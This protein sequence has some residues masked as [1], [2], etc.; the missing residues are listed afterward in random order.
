MMSNK[1]LT[2]FGGSGFVASEIVYKLHNH[3]N[4]VR[5]LTRNITKCNPLKVIN[6]VDV[7][8]Y[9][10]DTPSTYSEHLKFSNVVINTVGILNESKNDTFDNI[11]YMF[12]KKI[13][14]LSKKSSVN[15]LIH[16]SAL[17]ADIKGPSKYLKSKGKADEYISAQNS[18]IFTTIIFRPSIVFGEKDSFFNRF[19]NLLKY[20]P[21]FPLACP[22]SLFSPIYVKDLT[23]FIEHAILYEEYDNKILNI[24]GPKN[25]RFIDL[26]SFIL[27]VMNIKRII[28][29]LNY[30]L[31]K[32]QAAI[33]TILPGKI[34]TLDNFRSLQI[35][36]ITEDG[37]KGNTCI[38]DVVPTYLKDKR[39]EYD[40]DNRD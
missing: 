28:L 14:D 26:I 16:I 35:D 38:E 3:F 34:F 22:N 39:Y 5:L 18:N 21:I 33:F 17:N 36:N 24:T 1:V 7:Y 15:K 19:A 12:A 8:L 25:Y 9:D 31:S 32:L 37:L 13:T 27:K 30:S 2:I 40:I 4:E 23:S 29:P 10:P 11:H 6:N 20:I